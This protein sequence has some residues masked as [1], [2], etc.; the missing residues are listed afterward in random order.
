MTTPTTMTTSMIT[1]ATTMMA[2]MVDSSSVG[3]V[4]LL[5]GQV[6]LGLA[7]VVSGMAVPRLLWGSVVGCVLLLTGQVGLGLA[8]VVDDVCYCLIV[9]HALT[10]S[11][12]SSIMSHNVSYWLI[13]SRDVSYCPMMSPVVSVSLSLIHI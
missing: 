8:S 12:I 4:L 6:G 2:G 13:V 9:S 10:Y 11:P 3:C 5:T 7:S 1:T